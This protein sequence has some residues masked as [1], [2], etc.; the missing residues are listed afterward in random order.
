MPMTALFFLGRSAAGLPAA[1]FTAFDWIS[2][3]LPGPIVTFG[4]DSMVAVIRR[5]GFRRISGA[6]KAAE[7]SLAVMGFLLYAALAG[8]LL[9]A[10]FR[11][12]GRPGPIQRFRHFR[13]LRNGR[14]IS[15]TFLGF[16]AGMA[17]SIPLILIYLGA[18]AFTGAA[19]FGASVWF[20]LIFA[21][22]GASLGFVYR[23]LALS[24]APPPSETTTRPGPGPVSAESLDRRTFLIRVGGA[25][26]TLTVAGAVVSAWLSTRRRSPASYQEPWSSGHPL[27]NAGAEVRPVPGTRP[28][29]TPV[30]EHYRID[31]NA[32]AP[33]I[34]EESWRL[35]IGG[36]AE[37]P[38]EW[39][40][41][42]IRDGFPP[43]DLFITLS[44]ISNPIAGSLIGTQRW[45]G[46]PLK[47]LL[48]E[49]RPLASAAFLNIRA[50]DGYHESLPLSEAMEDERV[51]LAYAW[52]GLPLTAE[53]GFP[54]RIYRPDHYGMKQPKWIERIDLAGTAEAGYWVKRGWDAEARM[55]ITSVIDT[56]GTDMETGS[57][58]EGGNGG[59]AVPIG[60][61]A[62]GGA[63][64]VSRVE[65][66]V[67]DGPWQPARIR[68]PLSGLTWVLWRFDWPFSPGNHV[69]TVRCRDGAGA[70][71]IE[72][73]SPV[74][75]DGA[76][77][78]HSEA[79]ML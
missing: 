61:I 41:A 16:T 71:Q 51:M 59:R 30:G 26:A 60:G 34:P 1:P 49:V 78:L 23:R 13:D 15:S 44:C 37:R 8:A 54:L 4:I 6:A 25:A 72:T 43:Q 7:Q 40:L 24:S 28:E 53:H 35:R 50:A 27:P 66:R 31:I 10:L 79:V 74:R 42:G 65:V 19:P 9:F 73:R 32:G 33:A 29:L 36:L 64:G 17:F 18:R 48:E 11:S 55:R 21:A 70:V 75:P 76:T 3:K 56:V 63:R 45:T 57:A 68:A 20:L 77:G 52:D 2:R 12:L 22:W 62:H 5:A 38:K 14:G 58:T 69:F 46:V 39:T 47:R 67:D